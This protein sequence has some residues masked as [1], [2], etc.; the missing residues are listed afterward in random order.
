MKVRI[1]YVSNSSSSSF[2][3]WGVRLQDFISDNK[4]ESFEDELYK[5]RKLR[6]N[7]CIEPS[8][9]STW[10]GISE[11]SEEDVFIGYSPDWQ[12]DEET[13]KEFKTKIV[14][15]LNAYGLP[16]KIEDIQLYNDGGYDG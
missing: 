5:R 10:N 8:H 6:D 12:K 16:V 13:L 7:Y 2:C 3:I 1:G 9:I 15:E 11:Y 4:I 14:E